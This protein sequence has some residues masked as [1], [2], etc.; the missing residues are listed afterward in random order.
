MR[1]ANEAVSRILFDSVI[2]LNRQLPNRKK[3]PSAESTVL[4]GDD[5]ELDSLSLVT[6]LV[7]V[8][9]GLEDEFGTNC[10]L[11]DE[12]SGGLEDRVLTIGAL[13]DFIL[14]KLR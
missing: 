1:E 12:I 6:L 9:E 4:H 7:A 13:K 14:R 5:G 2:L 10:E 11:M 3:I 8:E